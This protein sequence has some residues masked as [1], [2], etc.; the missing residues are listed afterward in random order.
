MIILGISPIGHDTAAT[1]TVDGDIVAAC[2]QERYSKDKHSSLFPIDAIHDCLKIAN[3]SINQIDMIA[4]SWDHIYMLN[5]YYLKL[6]IKNKSRL[7][8]LIKDIDRVKELFNLEDVIKKKLKFQGSIKFFKHHLCHLASSYY[9]S[10]FTNALL[11]SYDG[12]GEIDTM[13]IG[14]G[15]NGNISLLNYLTNIQI[16]L[17]YY[18]LQ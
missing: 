2:E 5:E 3:L 15:D 6:A 16:H 12:C 14:S 18:M 13:S 8:F 11:V 4:V 17:G 10:G 1:I 9:S 7:D